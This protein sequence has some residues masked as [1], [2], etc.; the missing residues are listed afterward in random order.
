MVLWRWRVDDPGD[1]PSPP[2]NFPAS[3]SHAVFLIA[4]VHVHVHVHVDIHIHI[5]QPANSASSFSSSIPSAATFNYTHKLTITK[6]DKLRPSG[7]T[8]GRSII[9]E[10]RQI[11]L[12][13]SS[14]LSSRAADREFFL[15]PAESHLTLFLSP[16]LTVGVISPLIFLSFLSFLSFLIS[17][18]PSL[19][20]SP[21]PP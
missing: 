15:I 17:F 3:S 10:P 6:S 1:D 5:L 11:F 21:L 16:L 4:H 18:H 13:F 9:S 2:L 20:T 19:S 7:R 14:F 12:P 8:P